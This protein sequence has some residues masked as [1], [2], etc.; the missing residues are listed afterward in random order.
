MQNPD[1]AAVLRYDW[2]KPVVVLE[3]KFEDS[4]LKGV[5]E[6]AT[7][8]GWRILD[9]QVTFGNILPGIRPIGLLTHSFIHMPLVQEFQAKGLPVVRMGLFP[10]PEDDLVL[11]AILP[12]YAAAGRLAAEHFAEHNFKHLA[13]VGHQ[14]WPEYPY[15]YYGFQKR[16]LELGCECHLLQ[17]KKSPSMSPPEK[18][19]FLMQQVSDWL[20]ELPK[21]VG[22]FT[23]SDRRAAGIY[24]RARLDGLESPESVA[25]LGMGN[26]ISTCELLP[27]PLSSIDLNH[28]E[29]G[30][31]AV[32][33]LKQLSTGEIPGRLPLMIAPKGIVERQSTNLMAVPDPVVARALR[34]IWDHFLENLSVD[35]VAAAAAVARSTICRK[36]QYSLG[37][38]VNAELRRKRLE[39]CK[40]LLRSTD[41]PISYI[42]NLCGFSSVKYLF[43]IFR[44]AYG[45]TPGDY[46]Q[47]SR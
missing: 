23:Y 21:P 25:L 44:G 43:K 31:Q 32:A 2:E 20:A 46:R 47:Q 42:A 11:P 29:R 8:Y 10:H 24:A 39:H 22:V 9:L 19:H 7:E 36:F 14:P 40:T 16:G 34:F 4:L 28:E 1:H 38:G 18:F 6:Q 45:I 12:D 27:V 17:M 13:Y 35:D 15:A 41:M 26:N 33:L 3:G 5:F 30:R 37:R